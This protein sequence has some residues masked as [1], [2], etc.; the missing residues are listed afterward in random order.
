[1]SPLYE[2]PLSKC[3]GYLGEVSVR[4]LGAWLSITELGGCAGWKILSF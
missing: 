3:S 4:P 2:R 1:M